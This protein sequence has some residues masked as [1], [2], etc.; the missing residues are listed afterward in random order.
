MKIAISSTG[1]DLDSQVDVR[2]GRCPHFIIAYLEGKELKGNE[3]VENTARAQMGGAGITAAQLVANKGVKAIITGNLGP[4]AFE[5]FSQLGIK[6][7]RGS[8]IV[9][10]V[11]D[12]FAKGELENMTG[13]TGPMGTGMSGSGKS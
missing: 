4:R 2:F 6:V 8:G 5:V 10:E 1:P 12:K 11:I 9:K 3:H 7:Y 13:P